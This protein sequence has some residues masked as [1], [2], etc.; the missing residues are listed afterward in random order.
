[1]L[2]PPVG[3]T[4]AFRLPAEESLQRVR[5]L[6]E[7]A[8]TAAW[9][10]PSLEHVAEPADAGY[11]QWNGDRRY[12]DAADQVENHDVSQTLDRY[13]RQRSPLCPS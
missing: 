6:S 12:E 2:S 7:Q 4:S 3:E 1:M 10:A 11:G 5:A 9:P 13:D 8:S